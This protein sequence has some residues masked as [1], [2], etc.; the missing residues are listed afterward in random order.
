M[1]TNTKK[2]YT[3]DE[4]CKL[5]NITGH[6]GELHRKIDEAINR[7]CIWFVRLAGRILK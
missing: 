6:E 1:K 5:F 7:A 4:A 3:I 2:Q